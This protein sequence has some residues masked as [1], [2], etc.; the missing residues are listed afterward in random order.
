MTA[1]DEVLR[2]VRTALAG[3]PAAAAPTRGYSTVGSLGPM[4]LLDLL[5]TRLIDYGATV[6]R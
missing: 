5:E 4:E 1:R 6:G 2:R 3:S